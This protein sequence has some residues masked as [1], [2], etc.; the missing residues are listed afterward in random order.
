MTNLNLTFKFLTVGD[1][2][3]GKTSLIQRFCK[4]V[5]EE[6]TPTVGVE[7]MV[8]KIKINDSPIQLQIWDTAGQEQYYSLAKTYYR[9]AVGVLL[10]FSYSSHSSLESMEKW[11]SEV[12]SLCH[13]HVK[14]LL[15]G[16]K[17]DLTDERKIPKAEIESF[18]SRHHLE[19]IETSAKEN[20][21]VSEAFY[22]IARNVLNAI[23]TNDI[24]LNS[25]PDSQ[26]KDTN[27]SSSSCTC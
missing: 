26:S 17:I 12:R 16:N 27:N 14:I 24:V 21:N 2:G 6:Q 13:P 25:S 1:S 7:F 11:L 10:V 9:D 22:R 18:I 20:I 3:V 4:K 8:R 23:T 5:F 19:Y 15:V